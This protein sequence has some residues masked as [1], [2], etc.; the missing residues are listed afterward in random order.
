M[1]P[2][3]TDRQ[4]VLSGAKLADLATVT[5][6][7]DGKRVFFVSPV[8]ASEGIARVMTGE[9]PADLFVSRT[10]SGKARRVANR[11]SFKQRFSVSPDGSRVAY[12]VLTDVKL[13]GGAERSEIWLTRP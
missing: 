9:T 4:M 11:H 6:T 12:E 1:N 2:D 13:V 7:R 3:G 8:E 10:G 5:L